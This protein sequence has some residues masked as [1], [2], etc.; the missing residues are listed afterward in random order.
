MEA[1]IIVS[2]PYNPAHRIRKYK[3][4]SHMAKCKKSSHVVDKAE[5]PIDKSHIVDRHLLEVSIDLYTMSHVIR[6]K[7]LRIHI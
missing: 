5:C 7:C 3:L 1:D 4:M 6:T 2:C